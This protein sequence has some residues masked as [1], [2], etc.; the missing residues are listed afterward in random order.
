ME[1]TPYL[2]SRAAPVRASHL[3]AVEC[4][5]VVS[6]IPTL[7]AVSLDARPSRPGEQ[8]HRIRLACERELA[9]DIVGR[10]AR[11]G[12]PSELW[13]RITT[14]AAR[15][16]DGVAMMTSQPRSTV[17]AQLDAASQRPLRE[18]PGSGELGLYARLLH[19]R[20]P[21]ALPRVD[22]D[23]IC[24]AMPDTIRCAW[25]AAAADANL[26][27]AAWVADR[28]LDAPPS[29]VAWESAAASSGRELGEWAYCSWAALRAESA[30]AHTLD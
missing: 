20:S 3:H 7:R 6:P 15:V 4:D 21:K 16:R 8:P 23:G 11:D 26:T 28:L 22:V 12:I 19:N 29:S 27:L 9:R 17:Q 10:A 5:R 13:V 18:V 1:K 14:E 24:V 30:D 25:L 2:S